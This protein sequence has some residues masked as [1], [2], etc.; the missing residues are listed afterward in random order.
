MNESVS[1]RLSSV[2]TN[3]SASSSLITLEPPIERG[4][5]PMG[6][7][8]EFQK[9]P[10]N[11]YLRVMHEK[12]DFVKV[13]YGPMHA[14]HMTHPDYI[15]RV[16]VDNNQNYQREKRGL[17]LLKLITGENLVTA[18][19]EAWLKQRRLLQPVFHRRRIDGFASIM[20]DAAT[21]MLDRWD[22]LPA[23]QPIDVDQEIQD[24]TFTIAGL[25]LFG[26]DL[27]DKSSDMG[28]LMTVSNEF[29][30]YR[31]VNFFAPPLWV[32][33]RQNR[34]FK[35]A[36]QR[37]AHLGPQM[38]KERRLEVAENGTADESGRRFDMMDLLLEARYEDTGAGMSDEQ[39]ITEI[40]TMLGAGHET[41][42]NSL[43]WTLYL[44][45]QH[46]D[47]EAKL[48]QEVDS[49]LGGRVPTVEDLTELVYTKMVLSESMRL[50]PASWIT[51]RQSVEADQ[52]GPYDLPADSAVLM[53]R[54]AIHRHP[55]FWND[56]ERFDPER[57][58]PEKE[59]EIH[60][61]AF[62]PFS[63]GPR[64]CIGESFAMMEG[65]LLLAMI[66]QRYR[67]T[68]IPGHVV[69]PYPSITLRMK[70][71]LRMILEK[72]G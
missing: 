46:P 52:F 53:S 59:K 50:Y 68:L 9:E 42:S 65:R 66:M 11:L 62:F 47:V 20:T 5:F 16:F 48:Q 19:G 34:K 27:S 28:Y 39:I 54:H 25:T 8:S 24:L 51:T 4:R 61:F 49:V 32:P 15:K 44:L 67:L 21:Q 7:A 69:E 56:P 45:S 12:G 1:D 37:L 33:T 22:N 31:A 14:Y 35:D 13:R 26:V 40:N 23:D 55:D 36:Q 29:F 60:R 57:F 58:A 30:T 71:G 38:V 18:E 6:C 10:L 70:Y 64:Q 72:R 2:A 63:R 43:S 17:V 41:T 3:S